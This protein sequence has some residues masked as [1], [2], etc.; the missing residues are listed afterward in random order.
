MPKP[1]EPH[2]AEDDRQPSTA[3]DIFRVAVES[4]GKVVLPAAVSESLGVKEGDYLVLR[5]QRDGTVV[6][7]SLKQ[8]VNQ[9]MGHFRDVAPGRS[10]ADD[11]IADRRKEALRESE[12]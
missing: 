1:I 8:V 4:G 12:E 10:L 2:D 7:I 6:M 3:D 11:L 9:A 5:A